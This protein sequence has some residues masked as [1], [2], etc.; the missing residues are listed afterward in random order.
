[1]RTSRGWA[2]VPSH[3]CATVY[4]YV[5]CAPFEARI[6][7]V[8]P[9]RLR[10]AMNVA[11]SPDGSELY[12][13][14]HAE[15][16]VSVFS[17]ADGSTRRVFGERIHYPTGLAVTRS[18]QI[19]VADSANYHLG[20]FSPD[21]TLVRSIRGEWLNHPTYLAILSDDTVLVVC[22]EY[23]DADSTSQIVACT[24]TGT[25][26]YEWPQVLE[27]GLLSLCA[28]PSDLII[29]LW[30]TTFD[31][32]VTVRVEGFTRHGQLVCT[33][34]GCLLRDQPYSGY[35]SCCV[36]PRGAHEVLVMER[37]TNHIHVFRTNGT[38]VKTLQYNNVHDLRH[39]RCTRTGQVLLF[40][41]RSYITTC[42][43]VLE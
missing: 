4:G 21:G 36:V 3:L 24:L 33:F 19:I 40:N 1:M 37:G 31:S 30:G 25:F 32:P 38:L 20:V 26:L 15:H 23:G 43:A 12:A 39:A 16:G 22:T 18:G 11:L 17:T 9:L 6:V 28:T 29:L 2:N 10:N 5:T 35:W 13:T 41:L 14:L 7:R 42:V 27:R 34:G 8:V